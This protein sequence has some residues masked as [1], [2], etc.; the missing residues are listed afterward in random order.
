MQDHV[1]LY[2][3]AVRALATGRESVFLTRVYQWWDSVVLLRLNS[4]FG[5]SDSLLVT[6][7]Q[8]RSLFAEVIKKFGLPYA[9]TLRENLDTR[10]RQLY[11][12]RREQKC[13]TMWWVGVAATVIGIT[14]LLILL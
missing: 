3:E 13:D 14:A 11:L 8:E 10:S 2:R 6:L 9:T 1:T 12:E 5:T 7:A 4:G